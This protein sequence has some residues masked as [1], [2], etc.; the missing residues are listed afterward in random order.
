MTTITVTAGD[1]AQAMDKIVER[2]GDDA[3][4]L[5]TIKRN[6]QI[7][8]VATND[9]DSLPKKAARKQ[10]ARVTSGGDQ[11]RSRVDIELGDGMPF[12]DLFDQQM[13]H[14]VRD[15]EV[16]RASTSS[17]L[18]NRDA[19][20]AGNF[21]ILTELRSIRKMMNG[22]MITQP[23]GL[24]ITLGHAPPVQLHQAGF[25]SEVIQRLHHHME[26]LE[27]DQA[28]SA[29]MTAL[30]QRV[31][32][33]D[34]ESMF[35]SRLV[36]VVGNSG[37]GK[38]T[39]ATKIAAYLKENGS[40]DRMTLASATAPGATA[41]EEIKAYSRL[42][43]M[44]SSNFGIGELPTIM[45]ETSNRLIVDIDASPSDAI[46]AINAVIAT[47]GRRKVT[48]VQA[49]SGGSS[50][51]MISNQCKLYRALKPM[52]AL[53]K[54]DECEAMPSELSTLALEGSGVGLLTGTK[55]IVSGI[56]IATMPILAQY[57]KENT[58]QKV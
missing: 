3:M 56:A 40:S 16:E 10:P 32:H 49:I 44:R 5:E 45:Q 20:A 46:E 35:G 28:L 42:L 50:A 52:I 9:P 43:N 31:V 6:G 55:A 36:C 12:T 57:L 29:F 58:S 14:A 15:R 48:V 17:H 24:D 4:I 33:H 23:E 54:L 30:A 34:A 2:L 53:T 13:I 21:D 22:M 8:M 7:E 1:T 41:G 51:T 25:T 27:G 47:L 37:A 39:L 18:Q 19:Q 26:G 11:R 38:T